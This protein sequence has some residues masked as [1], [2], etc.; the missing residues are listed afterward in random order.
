[1]KYFALAKTCLT[2]ERFLTLKHCAFNKKKVK[3]EVKIRRDLEESGLL[4]SFHRTFCPPWGCAPLAVGNRNPTGE[5]Q[6]KN[7]G[8]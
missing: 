2:P 4:V 8:F 6:A 7:Q 5:Q 3:L 1:M